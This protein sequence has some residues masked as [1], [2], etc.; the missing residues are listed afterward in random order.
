MFTCNCINVGSDWKL[1][2]HWLVY[3]HTRCYNHG[4]ISIPSWFSVVAPVG[5]GSVRQR[6]SDSDSTPGY[7]VYTKCTNHAEQPRGDIADIANIL[8][9]PQSHSTF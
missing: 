7:Q 6:P 8:C 5:S 9:T 2:W 3:P 4:S 1:Y